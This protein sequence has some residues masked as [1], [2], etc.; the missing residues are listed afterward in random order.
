[1]AGTEW[2]GPWYP[3]TDPAVRAGLE[4]QLRLEL[5]ERH[6]LFGQT[7]HFVARRHDTD[8]ALFA[9]SNGRVAEVHLTWG[10]RTEQDPRWPVTAIFNSMEEWRQENMVRL[11]EELSRLGN[12]S[13]NS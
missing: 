6:V 7:A 2:L 10:K 3:V 12:R 8:D 9:L 5:S 1:M 11:H 13:G 4:A